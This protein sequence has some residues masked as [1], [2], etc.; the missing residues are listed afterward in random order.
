MLSPLLGAAAWVAQQQRWCVAADSGA[1]IYVPPFLPSARN[2]LVFMEFSRSRIGL[3]GKH[4]SHCGRLVIELFDCD[5][6]VLTTNFRELCRG[7]RGI[8]GCGAPLAYRG[9]RV[10]AGQGTVIAGD[11][12]NGR[13]PGGW[14]IYGRECRVA[15]EGSDRGGKGSVY[16]ICRGSVCGSEFAISLTDA[17]PGE[18]HVLLGQVLEGYELLERIQKQRDRPC[19]S[20]FVRHHVS[21]AGVVREAATPDFRRGSRLLMF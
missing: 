5:S 3:L 9:T 21:D 15:Q 17:A 2:S 7:G 19:A 8:C 12:T 20:L 4:A 10:T 18:G 1:S 13:V 11:I 6:P 16:A 14:S